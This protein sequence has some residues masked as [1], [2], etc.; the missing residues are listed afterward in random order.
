MTTIK[1][2]P[3]SSAAG[4][5]PARGTESLSA[6]VAV[7]TQAEIRRFIESAVV[8]KFYTPG[9]K[10][11]PNIVLA[12]SKEIANDVVS[13]FRGKASESA[14][15]GEVAKVFTDMSRDLQFDKTYGDFAQHDWAATVS[16]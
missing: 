12:G 15:R 1:Q 10:V 6:P 16:K 13:Q 9:S 3:A 2:M 7:S 14:V 5:A 4:S 8:D 11:S